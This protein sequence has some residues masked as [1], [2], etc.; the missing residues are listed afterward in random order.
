MFETDPTANLTEELIAMG[1]AKRRKAAGEYPTGLPLLKFADSPEV[2]AADL[3]RAATAGEIMLI[4]SHVG[5][6]VRLQEAPRYQDAATV[7]VFDFGGMDDVNGG[8]E[9]CI[10][11]AVTDECFRAAYELLKAG[12]LHLPFRECSFIYRYLE[13]DRIA[14]TLN[15]V[16]CSEADGEITGNTFSKSFTGKKRTEKWRS[17]PM[18]F[19]LFPGGD[20]ALE[21]AEATR[22]DMHWRSEYEEDAHSKYTNVMVS[23]LL[24]ARKAVVVEVVGGPASPPLPAPLSESAIAVDRP[25][26]HRILY[27]RVEIRRIGN[28]AVGH[29]SS[30]RP[31]IR[32]GHYRTL[33]SGRIVPVRPARIR[34]GSD[35]TL[36]Y[37]AVS[38]V[39]LPPRTT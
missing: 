37:Q 8:S 26:V 9:E 6:E 35:D 18:Q 33:R 12:D 23:L 38:D 39:A 7:P 17:E 36:V 16:V 31:H 24:L 14:D 13:T 1:E 25:I 28:E 32:R 21:L 34:G 11:K 5:N 2:I 15:V 19:T 27:N 30:P 4:G 20:C 10:G 3:N 29:H 22:L